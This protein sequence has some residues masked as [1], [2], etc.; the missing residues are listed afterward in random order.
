VQLRDSATDI[1]TEA[2]SPGRF[3]AAALGAAEGFEDCV[4]GTW[5]YT[6][7]VVAYLHHCGVGIVQELNFDHF[8][9]WRVFDGIVEQVLENLLNS[10]RVGVQNYGL[11]GISTSKMCVAS[12]CRVQR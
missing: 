11:G 1:Q 2:S 7:S 12:T 3:L 10:A 4:Y 8:A 9:G 6:D 5:R